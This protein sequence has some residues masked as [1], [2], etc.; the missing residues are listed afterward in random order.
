MEAI[1][2]VLP[3]DGIGPE[4]VE[5]GLRV[6]D[7]IERLGGHRFHTHLGQ[8]GAAAIDKTG[9]PLP[10]ET[11]E[12]CRSSD[13]ILLGAVGH[14]RYSG[15][16]AEARPEQGLLDL[17]AALG[18]YANLRPVRAYPQLAHR[19]PLRADL[20]EGVD[21]L[22]VRE[23]TGGIYFGARTSSAAAASD[24]CSY[25]V[26]EVE[27]IARH[28]FRAARV[29]GGRVVSIDKANV[30]ETSRLWR[31]TVERVHREEFPEMELEHMLVDAAAM[32]LLARP[33]EFDVVVTEN[34]FGDILS[35]E[36]SVLAGS[37][38]ML[39]SAALG[40]APGATPTGRCRGLYE[41]VHG[42][43]N[44]LAGTDRA[45]PY[46]CILSVAL[47]LRYSLGLDR[48]AARVE[49]AVDAA[50]GA[51]KVSE[52]MFRAGQVPSTTSGIGDA[53]IAAL[54]GVEAPSRPLAPVPRT[55][56]PLVRRRYG[57]GAP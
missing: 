24:T 13:A 51:G 17:R 49:A 26:H 36:I 18:L 43:A 9:S 4:V 20:L 39:P 34:L 12:S 44:A 47:M 3:G 16:D 21:I 11:L 32:H 52:D 48:E 56:T 2:T 33:R 10:S 7:K 8:I 57:A 14:P 42:A 22:L 19:A 45:N 15:P 25:T 1:I 40:E 6:L 46:G 41:P 31:R 50:L 28:A 53:V 27:R 37:L 54:S 55:S 30:L 38:G 29:R 5:Q 35:D 23:L